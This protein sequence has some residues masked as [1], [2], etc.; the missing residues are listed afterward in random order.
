MTVVAGPVLD[1]VLSADDLAFLGTITTGVSSASALSRLRP[2][3]LSD[4]GRVDALVGWER[5]ASWVAAQQHRVLAAMADN[6][7]LVCGRPDQGWVR[8]DVQAALGISGEYAATR[9]TLAEELVH[10]L[11][12]TLSLLES[13][14]LSEYQ[15]RSVAE[16]VRPL[17]DAAAAEVE[18]GMLA[19]ADL[20][21]GSFRRALRRAVLHADPASAEERRH[22]TLADRRVRTRVEEPGVASLWALLPAEGSAAV[23]A[24][25]D[26]MADHTD[27]T[28]HT[29]RTDHTDHTERATATEARTRDQ[30]R[31]DA[32]VQLALDRLAGVCA[33]CGDAP[34]GLR[35][36]IQVTVALST[37]LAMD[38]QPGELAG[39]GPIPAQLATALATDPTGTWRRLVTDQHG[40]LIDVGR[41]TYR[42]PA[43]LRRQVITRDRTCRFPGCN[44]RADHSDLDH[45]TRWADG[46]TT[47][48][49]NLHALDARHHHAKDEHGW[50]PQRQ[51][52]GTTCWTSPTGHSYHVPPEQLPND[53]TTTLDPDP[54]PQDPAPPPF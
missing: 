25:L 37:L 30:R 20:S 50:T 10:R 33:H 32:L 44:R 8:E 4:A 19:K 47:S 29:D 48:H 17:T 12:D 27:H 14:E 16:A 3:E 45:L 54:P 41:R 24:A 26:L 46:G 34:A 22:R 2:E 39:H 5:L 35:P 49:T 52:D 42:P 6:P 28:D 1:T 31:A 11:P 18:S 40:T 15:A 51:P 38:T 21:S 53:Q 13:G 23:M 7:V 36:A 9:L 43:A